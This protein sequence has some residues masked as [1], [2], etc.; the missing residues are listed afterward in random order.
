MEP[1]NGRKDAGCLDDSEGHEFESH[2]VKT[3][4]Q[5]VTGERFEAP[6]EVSGNLSEATCFVSEMSIPW[7]WLCTMSEDQNWK[8][9]GL[10][11][12]GAS[13]VALTKSS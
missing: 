7:G 11:S 12:R 10:N 8:V 4:L 2:A 6:I 13:Y 1:L 5:L 9:V 3:A